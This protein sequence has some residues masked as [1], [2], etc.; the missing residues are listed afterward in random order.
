ML[1][2]GACLLKLHVKGES[3]CKITSD[4][5]IPREGAY[6]RDE[7]LMPIQRRAC[8]MGFAEKRRA[9]A[10]DRI[11]YPLLQTLERGNTRGFK[12]ISW[13]EALD[14]AAAWY[15]ETARRRDDLGYLPILDEGGVSS[16]MGPHL[17][18][19]GNPSS[20]NVRAAVFGAIGKFDDLQSNPVMDVFNAEYIVIWG[21]DVHTNFPAYAFIVMKAKE[22]GIPITVVDS[23]Y[24]D[25]AAAMGTDVGDKPRCI[26]V[27]PGSDGALLA[28]MANVIYRRDLHDKQFLNTYCFGFYPDD[29]VVSR[30]PAT[31]PVT[32]EPYFGKTFTVPKGQSFVEYLDE[33]EREHGGYAGVL[34]W[35][36]RLTGT[37]KAVI[38][39]FAIEYASAKA[40]FLFSKF[41]GPQRENN[42]MYF[43]W[44]LIAIS[45][46]TGNTNKRGGGYGDV[47]FD[48]GYFVRMDPP[49]PFSEKEPHAPIYFSSF[50]LND[51]LLH[52]SDGR[53]PAQLREDVLGMN[54]IDLG[55][56]AR[57]HL[58][59]Y[60]RGGM[61]GNIFN[62]IPHIN[63]RIVA[64][65][66]LKYV[67]AYESTM[68][69]TAAWSDLIL[70]S[71]VG[72]ETVCFRS[73]IV[74]DVF[75]VNG[76]MRC[77]YEAKP[78]RWIN[79]QLA[80]RL[81]IEYKPKSE[82]DLSIMRRQ[83]ETAELPAGYDAID[84]EAR[85][86]SF[87][88]I[89]A[90]GNF[91]L[92]V[93]KEH[94]LIQTARIKP[95]EFDTDTGRINFYSP[96]FAERGRAVL[97][98]V[99]AQYVRSREGCEDALAGGKRGAKGIVY[100]LQFITPHVSNRALSTFG[101]IPMAAEQKPHTVSM[102]ADDAA[103]RN[104]RDGDVVYV[105]NDCGCIKLPASITR[106]ILPGIVSIG[107]GATYRPSSKERY[108][109]FFDADNDGKPEPHQTPVDVGACV[110]TLTEDINSGILDP[111]FC[112]LGLNAGGALCE[113]SKTK[114]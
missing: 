25:C 56:D 84:P 4:G 36:E 50:K 88:E 81:G 68:T 102:H 77:M 94:S 7:A 91:Q 8:S 46:M 111:Y 105:F 23:R 85:L 79:E 89:L 112:G 1:C 60:V 83:W 5:D 10:P 70:P 13:N 35:A 73:Q 97:K 113:V 54:G 100:P 17:R 14:R 27:R 110:N 26:C 44:M 37:D 69:A 39:G 15:L 63:K 29:R 58:E 16:Y 9:F 72:F 38:E 30:S 96:Y 67:I 42:G 75:V 41:T 2:G 11:K 65:K 49:P 86:P 20:G 53:T 19:F 43:S 71:A 21:N 106:R 108:E 98:A 18:R 34:A 93:P 12:R 62:Q 52:G 78:D 104:I 64:W 61:P 90:T 99:R 40:A 47:R 74:S 76:P 66:R 57:L 3:V 87:E 45:A 33:L 107:Q 59:M 109:A 82:D 22:A 95:G 80:L 101:N 48:D 6:A 114:P 32:G 28:A 55:A 51:V 24:T 103:V 31:H 92:P